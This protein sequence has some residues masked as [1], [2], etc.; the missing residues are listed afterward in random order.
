MQEYIDFI[1][2]NAALSLAWVGIVGFLIYS[3]VNSAISKVKAVN[4][5]QATLLINKSDATIV[6]IRSAEEYRK[7]HILNAINVSVEDVAANKIALIE[8]F[9]TTP[10]IVVCDTGM[11]SNKTANLLVK[12]GFETVHMLSGGMASWKEANLPTVKK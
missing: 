7:S 9:K 5:H 3:M 12:A 11:G 1:S 10:I 4:N 6:D 8:K 2:K